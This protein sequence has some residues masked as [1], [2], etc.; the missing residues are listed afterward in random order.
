SARVVD[1]EV[2]AGSKG[3]TAVS[4]AVA[5][6][7]DL[8]DTSTARLGASATDLVATGQVTVHATH[9][10]DISK[11][12]ANADAGG[13][14]AVGAGVAI[15]VVLGWSTAASIDRN[16]SGSGVS[17]IAESTMSS[18]AKAT[19]SA[20]GSESSG[21]GGQS[22]D[23]TSNSQISGNSNTS[24]LSIPSLPSSSDESSQGNDQASSESGDSGGGVGVAAAIA[25]N[26][27]VTS[28]MATIAAGMHVTGTA[29]PVDVSA[30]DWTDASAKA[31]GLS[32]SLEADDNIGAAVGLN[33]VDAT[34]D[35]TI[36]DGAVV[37]GH[38]VTVEAI[39]PV[40]KAVGGAIAVNILYDVET[41]ASIGAGSAIV[42][43]GTVAVTATSGLQPIQID[44]ALTY[45]TLPPVNSVAVAGGAGTGDASVTGSVIVDV[46]SLSTTA[47]IGTG[48]SLSTT[49][50]VT[51]SATDNTKIVNLAGGIALT[52]GDAGVGIGI[53]VEVILKTVAATI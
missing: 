26:W 15:N 51:V 8:N 40:G 2:T 36:G 29:S 19:A 23:S 31:T 33:V 28:N 35:A 49:G 39:T 30:S 50:G 47:W 41:Q 12:S 20:E 9:T 37:S 3:G 4:P 32:G 53:D 5:L 14:D 11:T 52:T 34:N 27:V 17:V 6:V 13:D 25:V 18:A 43:G 44:P 38:G 21:S 1:T 22:A 16:V 24:G 42:A 7:V 46:F 48:V 45:F 10:A